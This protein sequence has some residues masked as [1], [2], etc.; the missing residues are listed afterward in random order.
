MSAGTVAGITIGV[1][2]AV[3]II[4]AVAA[5]AIKRRFAANAD[6]TARRVNS[7][8]GHELTVTNDAAGLL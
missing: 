3:G 8:P 5:I 4:A 7:L 1:I 6:S 2:A